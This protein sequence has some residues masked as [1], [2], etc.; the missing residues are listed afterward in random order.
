MAVISTPR[1]PSVSSGLCDSGK[2][3]LHG[4]HPQGILCRSHKM[5]RLLYTIGRGLKHGRGPGQ[6]GHPKRPLRPTASKGFFFFIIGN[7]CSP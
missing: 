5:A 4:H 1:Y 6:E 7:N 3:L 2:K